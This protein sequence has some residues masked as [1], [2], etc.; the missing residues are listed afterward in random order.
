[1][2][3][4]RGEIFRGSAEETTTDL[5]GRIS[6]TLLSKRLIKYQALI[7]HCLEYTSAIVLNII[8]LN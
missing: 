1:M 6:Q 7:R 4:R 3:C 5:S 2:Y 8:R